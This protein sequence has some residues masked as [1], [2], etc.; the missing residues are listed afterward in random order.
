VGPE[1]VS[2]VHAPPTV[3]VV[4]VQQIWFGPPH[5][6]QVP[7]LPAVESSGLQVPKSGQNPKLA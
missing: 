3:V 4:V 6:S 2:P 5:A 7:L 1:N